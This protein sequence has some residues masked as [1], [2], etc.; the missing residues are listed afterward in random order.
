MEKVRR[1]LQHK[2]QLNQQYFK[3]HNRTLIENTFE[4]LQRIFE[5]PRV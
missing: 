1:L 3:L 4:N 2:Q 5:D